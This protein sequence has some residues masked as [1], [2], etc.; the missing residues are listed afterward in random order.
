MLGVHGG[1]I[2]TASP[3]AKTRP[4]AI[5]NAGTVPR[6][7]TEARDPDVYSAQDSWAVH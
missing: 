3:A 6:S 1:P 4:P 7:P 2:M 5:E